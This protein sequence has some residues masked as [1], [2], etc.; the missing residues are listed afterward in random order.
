[1]SQ[2]DRAKTPP[3][4]MTRRM[5]FAAAAALA[6]CGVGPARAYYHGKNCFLKG[7]GIATLTG[8]RRIED[9]CVGDIVPTAFGGARP[10]EWIGRFRRTRRDATRPWDKHARPV[11]IARGALAPNVPSADLFVTGGHALLIDG[12]LIPAE[13]LINDTTISRYPAHE[14]DELEFFH[15]KL[16]S[17][18]VIYAEGAPCESL[19]RVDETMSNASSYLRGH[20]QTRD[21]H[22]APIV[23]NGLRAQIKTEVKGLLSPS[24]GERQLD[25]VR[26]RLDARAAALTAQQPETVA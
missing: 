6:G 24:R 3:K 10:I 19:L 17:H 8:V 13:C 5:I 21:E 4:A 20:G 23:G 16:D 26:A 11:R 25:L 2:A 15:I 9:L 1:M 18:D 22:C 7:T 14:H 12:L